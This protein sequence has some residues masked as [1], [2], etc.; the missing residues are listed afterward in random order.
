MSKKKLMISALLS[1]ILLIG[2][3]PLIA[4]YAVDTPAVPTN[5]NA[6]ATAS[7]QI[8]LSWKASE[9]ANKYIIYRYNATAKD[10]VEFANSVTTSYVDNTV[11]GGYQYYYRV[12]AVYENGSVTLASA[13]S[14]PFSAWAVNGPAVPANVTAAASGEKQLTISWSAVADATQYNVYR[15]NGT[16]QK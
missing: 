12:Q 7:R 9:N 10:Y 11:Y 8:T 4:S 13:K 14:A 5:L 1:I 3:I 16:E 6:A 2:F 15:Y